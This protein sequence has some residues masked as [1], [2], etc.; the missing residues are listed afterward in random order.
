MNA[1]VLSQTH[2]TSIFVD[3]AKSSAD[4]NYDN[5]DYVDNDDDDD[6]DEGSG[7]DDFDY[8]RQQFEQEQV[9][10]V[11]YCRSE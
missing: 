5:E 10:T 7:D 2:Q 4:L 6:D 8:R 11:H 3:P 1:M 9:N